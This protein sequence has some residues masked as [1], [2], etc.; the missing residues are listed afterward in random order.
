MKVT[1]DEFFA[2]LWKEK[3]D[4]HPTPT[5]NWPYTSVF[6]LQKLGGVE[7]GRIV[8]IPGEGNG[9]QYFIA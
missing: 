8:P 3:R 9:E 7:W 1:R 2:A 5:G 6:K 4:I